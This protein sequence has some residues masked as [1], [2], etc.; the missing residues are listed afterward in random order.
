MNA[1]LYLLLLAALAPMPQAFCESAPPPAAFSQVAD[2]NSKFYLLSNH[3]S[4]DSNRAYR[5][6]GKAIDR[7]GRA[8][9]WKGLAKLADYIERTWGH[10]ADTQGYFALM[11][12]LTDVLRSNDFGPNADQERSLLTQK[13]V[14][15]ALAHDNPPLDIIASL[16]PRLRPEEQWKLRQ[17]PFNTA[18]WVELRR[19]RAP[20]WLQ[21]RQRIKLLVDP[22]YDMT[23]E[24][25]MNLPLDFE[26]AA[27]PN[28]LESR[29]KIKSEN[30]YRKHFNRL[31]QG[32]TDQALVRSLNQV[33]S[34]QAEDEIIAYYSQ[35]PYETPQLLHLMEVYVDDAAGQKRILV[36]VA[37]SIPPISQPA[38]PTVSK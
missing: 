31:I 2:K 33:F 16:L 34:R 10:N 37:K 15:A 21:T 29:Q 19:T 26:I 17:Q 13:Y 30:A 7:L 1:F 32:Q 3:N 35:P 8:G 36:E 24:Y 14:L 28:S 22:N 38:A 20:L 11:D 23:T 6:M 12:D 27:H 9:D 5:A 4:L 18:E 25:P